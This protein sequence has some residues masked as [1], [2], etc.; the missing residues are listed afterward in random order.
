MD[1]V[2]GARIED[3]KARPDCLYKYLISYYK[4]FIPVNPLPG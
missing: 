1:F 3:F 4:F 2:R